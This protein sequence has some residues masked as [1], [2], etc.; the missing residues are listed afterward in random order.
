MSTKMVRI[1]SLSLAAGGL[2]LAAGCAV[3][4]NGHMAFVVPQLVVAAPPVYVAPPAVVEEPF[5]VPDDY[6]MVDG[7]YMGLVGG[8]YFYLGAGGVWLVCDQARLERFHGWE[9]GHPDWRAHAIRNDRFRKDARG[10]AAPR[11][12]DRHVDAAHGPQ[13]ATPKAAPK[14]TEKKDD[15]NAK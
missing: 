12:D 14:K 1:C 2:A 15:K 3:D 13:K 8:Q 9:R 4:Q 5:M 7:E 6:V 10:Q 11:H